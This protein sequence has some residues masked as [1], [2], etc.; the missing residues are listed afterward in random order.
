VK[1]GPGE[2]TF[3][4]V[5]SAQLTTTPT[6]LER[7]LKYEEEGMTL[8]GPAPGTK[9][10]GDLVEYTALRYE[11]FLTEWVQTHGVATYD[12]EIAWKKLIKEAIAQRTKGMSRQEALCRFFHPG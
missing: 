12:A 8:C 10:S 7:L 2:F 6:R 3:S 4:Y 1:P 11:Q 5:S 9:P